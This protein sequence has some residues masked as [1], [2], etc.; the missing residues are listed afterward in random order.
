MP[1][2]HLVFFLLLTS[3]L[4]F[5]QVKTKK[6]VEFA[7]QQYKKGDYYYAI[8]YYQQALK[9]DSNNLDIQWKYAEVQRA[10]KNYL[11]A[12]EYYAKVFAR[13]DAK[14]YQA[15]ILQL[16]L[17]QKQ[18]GK[19]NKAFETFKLAKRKYEKDKNDF[20]YKKAV[21]EI[22]ATAWAISHFSDTLKPLESL[23]ESINT[24]NAEFGHTVKD[25]QLIFSSLRADSISPSE[26][27]YSQ[28]YKTHLFKSKLEKGVFQKNERIDELFNEK[29]NTGNGS[30]SLDGKRFFFSVCEDEGYNYKCK[31]LYSKYENGT[32]SQIDTLGKEINETGKNSTMPAISKIDGKEVLFFASDR[33]GTKGGLDIWIAQLNGTKVENIQNLTAVNS[34]ENEITPW[35][36]TL[37][38]RL[39]FSSTWHYGF[40]GQ[41]VFYA[42]FPFQ[43]IENVGIPFNSSANDQY[44]FTYNDTVYVSSNR[45]GTKYAKNPT[46]CSDIF[47]Q[48]PKI[49]PIA[50]TPEK[51]DSAIM[52]STKIKM[53]LPVRLYFRNDEPDEDSWATKTKQNYMTSYKLYQKNYELYKREVGKG[54]K[55]DIADKKRKELDEFFKNE[56]DKGAADLLEFTNLLL[57]ELTAGSKIIVS[58]KGF[59]SPLAKT[60]YNVNLT[61]RRISSLVNYFHEYNYGEFNPYLNG[62]AQNGGKLILEF[63]PFGEFSANQTTSDAADNKK[64]SVY[65]K[66]AGI[67]RKLHIEE[68]TFEKSKETFPLIAK[69]L[70]YNAGVVEKSK[71]ISG[72]F[73][74]E[75]RSTS[76][77]EFKINNSDANLVLNSDKQIIGPNGKAIVSF[78]FNT[79]VLKGFQ[80]RSFQ[81]EVSGYENKLE[82]FITT[83]V[84]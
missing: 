75:N 74:V 71:S 42:D 18:N 64:E 39:Y 11:V 6:L 26:E 79:S 53:K 24:V 67:E 44:F 61:K 32:W 50:T 7:D 1:R 73:I 4:S 12:E 22:D 70:V 36:D 27:V 33:T 63:V 28:A 81:L 17:M 20:L 38:N 58:I 41:D 37:K 47:A 72:N 49:I 43:K 23:P 35:Y 68:V 83:E 48:Y 54:L 21:Q 15:S 51:K 16:G 84:K 76:T 52:T 46:C 2:L 9:Q 40:G 14:T 60:D 69:E 13:D 56:V 65:S 82:L 19:Y 80:R 31:I 29:V 62:T 59:A 55:A 30:F 34:L 25:N 10:Y 78:N 77:V 57:Q 8:Q 5:G 66:E 3:A 45:L